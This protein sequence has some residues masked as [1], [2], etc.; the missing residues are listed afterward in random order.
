MRKVE[1]EQLLVAPGAFEEGLLALVNC[2]PQVKVCAPPRRS[3]GRLCSHR[4]VGLEGSCAIHV[5]R[6]EVTAFLMLCVRFRRMRSFDRRR[7]WWEAQ[8]P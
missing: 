7:T 2:G 6:R 8:R 1:F 3:T 5:R 4:C